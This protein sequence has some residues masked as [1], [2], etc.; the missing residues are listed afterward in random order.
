MTFRDLF[1]ARVEGTFPIFR[2]QISV[3]RAL[4]KSYI[5]LCNNHL[6]PESWER[7]ILVL[8]TGILRITRFTCTKLNFC[9]NNLSVYTCVICQVSRVR[10]RNRAE[11]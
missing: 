2:N 7:Q 10:S 3:L 9:D 5:F 11:H 8:S 6:W 4:R 1:I